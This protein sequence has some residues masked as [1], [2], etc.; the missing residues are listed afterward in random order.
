M[1]RPV[2]FLSL[3]VVGAFLFA[4]IAFG[5]SVKSTTVGGVNGWQNWGASNVNNNA[6]PYWDS[7][8]WDGANC[9]I[10]YLLA[11]TGCA[12]IGSP[13]PIPFWGACYNSTSD[14]GGQPDLN[15]FFRKDILSNVGNIMKAHITAY[16]G[17]GNPLDEFGWYDASTPAYIHSS[18]PVASAATPVGTVGSLNSCFSSYG[19]HLKTV[20]NFSGSQIPV[21]WRTEASKT[22]GLTI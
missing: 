15:F 16:Q 4:T 5:D 17:G 8:S 6:K 13:G 14:T 3:A 19:L 20:G 12:S 10:G 2:F 18:Y 9:N 21:V 1:K 11:N 7:L 22:R